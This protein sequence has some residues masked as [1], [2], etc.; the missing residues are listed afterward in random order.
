MNQTETIQIFLNSKTA[1]KYYDGYTSSCQFNLPHIVI[2]RAEAVYVSVQSASIPYSFYN[3]DDFN[4]PFV[5]NVNGG[6]NIT[7]TIPQGNYN[8]T[9]L[10]SYLLSVMT[11]FTITYSSLDNSFTFTHAS[12][13]FMFKSNSTCMEILGFPEDISHSS[14][15]RVLKSKNCINLFTIRN[16]YIQSDNLLLSNINHATP[17]NSN[18]LCSIPLTSGQFSVITYFNTNNVKSQISDVKNFTTLNISLTD[19]DGDILDLNGCHF[20]LTLQI[21]IVFK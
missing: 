7:I 4:D 17:N 21:D 14:S 19:Q 18:I 8:T 6:S 12:Y 1:N 10:R 9:T 3:V 2:P 11:G 20:S 5:Y 13:D 16:I 15:S